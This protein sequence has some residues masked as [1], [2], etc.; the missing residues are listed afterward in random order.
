MCGVKNEM[1]IRINNR[2]VNNFCH[3]ILRHNKN[4]NCIILM[5]HDIT[6]D[7]QI[8]QKKGN[9]EKNDFSI[10]IKRFQEIIAWLT[11]NDYRFVTIDELLSCWSLDEKFCVISFDD[12]YKGVYEFAYPYLEE[13]QIPYILYIAT[14]LLDKPGFISKQNVKEMSSSKLCTIGS[15]TINHIMTRFAG[16]EELKAEL[17]GS[18]IYLEKLIEKKVIHFAFPYGSPRAVSFL[19]LKYVK[20]A[21]Y[22]S[23]TTTL[24]FC[25][26]PKD[27]RRRYILP[28]IDASRSDLF[29]VVL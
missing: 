9:V 25:I 29:E 1:Y 14:G 2:I 7:S 18:K 10:D 22:K 15:H 8:A 21:G 17:I 3:Y 12:V 20:E 16:R 5:F 13:K 23:S 28:R 11:E 4:N 19:D 26:R 24:Q 6:H 27:I